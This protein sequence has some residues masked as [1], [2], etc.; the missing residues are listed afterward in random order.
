MELAVVTLRWFQL[1]ATVA[2]FGAALFQLYTG[3]VYDAGGV[4]RLVLRA[5]VILVL[6]TG[7]GL[8]AQTGMMAGSLEAA[9]DLSTLQ[10]VVTETSLGAGYA[11][12]FNAALLAVLLL[13]VV[14]GRAALAFSALLGAI[15]AGSFAWTGHAAAAVG[16]LA[17]FH[18]AADAL[19]AGAAGVWL[20]ALGAFVVLLASSASRDPAPVHRALAAFGGVGAAAVGVLVLSGLFNVFALVGWTNLPRLLTTVWGW[21][22]LTKVALFFFMLALAAVNRFHLTPSLGLRLSAGGDPAASMSA[23]R[24]SLVIETALGAGLLAV[25]AL[26]GTLPPPGVM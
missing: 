1:A 7:A 5:A 2:L 24:R 14:H 10:T 13:T 6:A 22:L 21:L 18:Q 9:L 23:L 19:H 8:L 11:A 3:G 25:V 20:G 15:A 16:T 26:M 17:P 12:R 4:R